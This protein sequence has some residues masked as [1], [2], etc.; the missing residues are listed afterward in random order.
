MKKSFLIVVVGL[1]FSLA[2]CQKA[3]V[4]EVVVNDTTGTEIS[5]PTGLANPASENCIK[6]G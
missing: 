3:S 6:Q 4:N 5:Q 1:V 2:G